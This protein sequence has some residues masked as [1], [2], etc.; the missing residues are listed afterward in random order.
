M[1]LKPCRECKKEV[2]TEAKTCPHC[3][4]SNP[5]KLT[6]VKGSRVNL[7][8]IAVAS[9]V[10]L[11]LCSIGIAGRKNKATSDANAATQPIQEAVAEQPSEVPA[12][13]PVLVPTESE[14]NAL[15]WLLTDDLTGFANGDDSVT[16][17]IA[18]LRGE[19]IAVTADE[20]QRAYE[21]NEVSADQAYRGKSILVRGSVDSINRGIGDN[22]YVSF[23][24]GS[25]MFIKPNAKM[26]D[27]HVSYLSKLS[28]GQKIALACK[29][30]GMLVG[31]AW[32]N[33]CVP[34]GSWLPG[35][36]DGTISRLPGLLAAGDPDIARFMVTSL[37]IAALLPP[38]HPC[39]AADSCSKEVPKFR[40]QI[41]A[42]PELPAQIAARV[43]LPEAD[44]KELLK[45][46]EPA[47]ATK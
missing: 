31:S 27:G 8:I 10:C 2:S 12:A 34:L 7:V 24:G 5:V 11:G 32:L 28:K 6:P 38:D 35:A 44:V 45:K 47:K 16:E 36:V 13:K 46:K 26:A 15:R 42:M 20:L 40:S 4:V 41:V 25:N 29:G 43:N 3:G 18:S 9:V 39:W 22:H 37:T 19:L 1:A 21:A 30:G 17:R 33:G 23:R 14:R